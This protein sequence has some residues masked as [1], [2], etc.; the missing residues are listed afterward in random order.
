[1]GVGH[2]EKQFVDADTG[3][4]VRLSQEPVIG[5]AVE[6]K[7]LLQLLIVVRETGKNAL[8]AVAGRDQA[9]SVVLSNI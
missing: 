1:M 9:V 4:Q 5:G 2:P 6:F 7:E 8:V 3:K